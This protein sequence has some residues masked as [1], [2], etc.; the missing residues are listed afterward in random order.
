MLPLNPC[1]IRKDLNKP[2]HKELKPIKINKQER[3]SMILDYNFFQ[4]WKI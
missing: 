4:E 2:K 1:K 3:T